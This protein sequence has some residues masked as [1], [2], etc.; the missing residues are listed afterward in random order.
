M[1]ISGARARHLILSIAV[2]FMFGSLMG[3]IFYEE[4]IALYV[5]IGVVIGATYGLIGGSDRR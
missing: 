5:V 3:R 4:N 2:G 1:N